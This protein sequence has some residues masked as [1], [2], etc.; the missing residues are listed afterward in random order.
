V[1]TPTS[2]HI[3]FRWRSENLKIF[4]SATILLLMVALFLTQA[5]GSIYNCQLAV[6]GGLTIGSTGENPRP[7]W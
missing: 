7:F 6:P 2:I 4:F 5:T 1:P 3:Y